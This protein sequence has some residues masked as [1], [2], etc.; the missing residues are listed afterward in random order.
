MEEFFIT[1][2]YTYPYGPLHWVDV[3]TGKQ[4]TKAMKEKLIGRP[5]AF[6]ELLEVYPSAKFVLT[7]RS[8]ES[9]ADS[10]DA[11]IYKA[12]AR[13]IRR[14]PKRRSGSRWSMA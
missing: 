13:E 6:R 10:F 5:R 12:L 11:T 2:L 8:P 14:H 1:C 9:W 4:S 7:V 3:L